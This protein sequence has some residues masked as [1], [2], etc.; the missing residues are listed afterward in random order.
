MDNI[1]NIAEI[2]QYSMLT[3]AIIIGGIWAL[4]RSV[5]RNEHETDLNI[6]ISTDSHSINDKSDIVYISISLDNRGNR[7][8]Y[9]RKRDFIDGNFKAIYKDLRET[10]YHS[11]GLQLKQINTKF[12]GNTLYTWYDPKNLSEVENIPTEINLLEDFE[13]SIENTANVDTDFGLTPGETAHRGIVVVLQPGHYLARVTFWGSRERYRAE[14]WRKRK[15]Y[16]YWNCLF[17]FQVLPKDIKENDISLQE[18]EKHK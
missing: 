2:T 15:K 13:A 17:Y 14:F 18:Q 7:R 5:I 11:C 4:Y 16:D 1:K 9:P 8:I 3:L 6:D 12:T 10:L